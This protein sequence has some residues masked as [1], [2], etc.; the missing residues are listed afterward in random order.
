M[1][2]DRPRY[3]LWPTSYFF[4]ANRD[5]ASR[6]VSAMPNRFLT[7]LL[8][9]NR[10][11]AVEKLW[12]TH[13]SI[14]RRSSPRPIMEKTS[15]RLRRVARFKRN[16]AGPQPP[17]R[18]VPAGRR[19]PHA[20]GAGPRAAR[21]R[22]AAL[23]TC[24]VG[25]RELWLAER[26][27]TVGLTFSRG[28]APCGRVRPK[29]KRR[30]EPVVGCGTPANEP[31]LSTP[32]RGGQRSRPRAGAGMPMAAALRWFWS[33]ARHHRNPTVVAR[34]IRILRHRTP[35]GLDFQHAEIV[36]DSCP[37]SM[38]DKRGLGGFGA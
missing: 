28:Q 10:P 16:T 24:V 13:R 15:A 34:I 9:V 17:S 37:N 27:P 14:P 36:S 11:R 8:T 3:D 33:S 35:I 23:A 25:Q 38:S 22:L 31:A 26:G 32:S 2:F 18:I 21:S 19:S 7:S 4:K 30:G 29:A 1:T 5:K 12:I 20:C 6:P